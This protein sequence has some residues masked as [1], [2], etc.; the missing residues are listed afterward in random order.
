MLH[1]AFVKEKKKFDSAVTHID[2]TARIQTVSRDD[3]KRYYDLIKKF[4]DLTEIPMLLD[5]SFNIAG[6]P[7][8]E[9]PLDAV[10]CFL[11]TDIDVL[12]INNFYIQKINVK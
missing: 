6:E 2:N 4:K 12:G 7:I 8:V 3:N 9:T 1:A 10:K 5:T 11:S